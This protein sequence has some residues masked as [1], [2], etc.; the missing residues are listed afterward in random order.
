MT[1]KLTGIERDTALAPLLAASWQL[2]DGRD[3]IAKTYQMVD[4]GRY[5]PS[6]RQQTIETPI[7]GRIVRL[8]D[9]VF[10]NAHVKK[11]QLIAEVADVDGATL[12]VREAAE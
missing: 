5:D 1:D 2:V 6:E 12:L 7:K 10:E 9:G 8:G 3:A 11:G 4:K